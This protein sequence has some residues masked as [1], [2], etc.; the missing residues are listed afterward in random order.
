MTSDTGSPGGRRRPFLRI[1]AAAFGVLALVACATPAARNVVPEAEVGEAK[2]LGGLPVRHW[3]NAAPKDVLERERLRVAQYRASDRLKGEKTFDVLALSGGAW[4]GAFGA[5]LLNGWTARGDRPDFEMV[6]GVSTGALMASFVFLGPQYDRDLKQMY[7]EFKT[8]DLVVYTIASGILG[9]SP[10]VA[11]SK[12]LADI[13]ARYVTRD[14]LREVA[15]EY[16]TGRRL[17]VV[18]TNLDAQRP[19]VWD[20]GLI[21]AQ[22]TP[23]S[24]DLFRK[25]LLASASVP[26]LFPPV[27]IPVTVN[28][29]EHEEL[30]VDG[31][32]TTEIYVAPLDMPARELVRQHVR[33]DQKIKFYVIWNGKVDPEWEPVKASTVSIAGRSISTLIK[34]QGLNDLGRIYQFSQKVD[35]DYYLAFIPKDFQEERHEI[36]DTDYMSKLFSLGYRL[37]RDGYDWSRKP[38]NQ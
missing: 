13:I 4:D 8:N 37:G 6:T 38:P 9:S 1:A 3:A 35:G 10:S 23:Q 19:V 31:G 33:R 12:P 29:T 28:G 15:A 34:Y 17:Y 26:A 32:A 27:R 24:L 5:G 14:F 16:K 2:P 11:D 25:V 22:D 36:F 18:T 21:A 7:T 30:H 20:M